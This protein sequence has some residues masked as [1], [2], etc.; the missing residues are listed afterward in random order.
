[1]PSIESEDSDVESDSISDDASNDE[2]SDEMNEIYKNES[3]AVFRLR[4]VVFVATLLAAVG[5]SLAVY[6]I[7]DD[8]ENDEYHAQ[9]DESAFTVLTSFE[10]IA[11]QQLAAIGSLSVAAT[12]Y[13]RSQPNTT[14]PFVTLNDF[15]QRADD[16]RLLSNSL[17][18]SI[19]P[20]VSQ[21]DRPAWED[22]SL[23]N[24]GWLEES[25][26]YTEEGLG[27]TL[28]KANLDISTGIGDQIYI[29]GPD[30]PLVDQSAGPY[31]PLWQD[32]PHFGRDMTPNFNL[33]YY[34]EYAPYIKKSLETGD[35]TLGGLDTPV[36]GDIHDPD[37]TTSFFARLLSV[38][39]E[40]AVAYPG[41]PMSSLFIPIFESFDTTR[42][43]TALVYS[44]FRWATYFEGLLPEDTP[45]V[46]VVLENTCDGPFTYK[47]V[48][49]Q[50]EYKGQGDRHDPAFDHMVRSV[51]FG[52]EDDILEASLGIGVNQDVC[53]YSLRVYPSQELYDK[54]HSSLPVVITIL[55]A[56]AMLMIAGAFL[57][58]SHRVEQR[59]QI[60][61]KQAIESNAIV[62][63]LFPEGVRDRYVNGNN[64][65]GLTS[66]KDR[67]KSF[68]SD[69]E[70]GAGGEMND[71]PIADLF[72]HTTVFFADIAGFTSWSSCREPTQVF[73]LLQT[74]YQAFDVIAKRRKVFKVETIGDSYVAVCGLP[75]P[76]EKH[77][78]SMSRFASDC[79]AKFAELT[80]E[81]E[82][83]LG[84]GTAALGLRVGLHR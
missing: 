84:P 15:Q 77:F 62:S 47:V 67:L 64:R 76:D 12:L 41:D 31:F 27:F 83:K 17:F 18:V 78:V 52:R 1:M 32:S 66:G 35:M 54:Y 7:M 48:G 22:Y 9:Y 60:V 5:V 45:G 71:T 14:W 56:V 53:A 33:A 29:I 30:G 80:N 74:I 24:I 44:V 58:Y 55:V 57:R 37:R 40:K 38:E 21:E 6:F 23:K 63:S 4:M 65:S 39:A 10:D 59:Q 20:V 2:D 50:A 68:L 69:G 82:E 11:A 70:G 81:L 61:L 51:T 16:I 25:R 43:A 73:I 79:L 75:K 19:I 36:P 34:P 13:A 28:Q 72:P 8:T 26:V 46:V 42:K 3:T 49:E